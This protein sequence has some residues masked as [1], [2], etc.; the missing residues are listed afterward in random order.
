ML[1]IIIG[2]SIL[3]LCWINI[4]FRAVKTVSQSCP[5]SEAEFEDLRRLFGITGLGSD[6]FLVIYHL[7]GV[8]NNTAFEASHRGEKPILIR[9]RMMDSKSRWNSGELSHISQS[10]LK[11]DTLEWPIN[12]DSIANRIRTSIGPG[13][14]LEAYA[15]PITRKTI[16]VLDPDL[17]Y[18]E[19]G[20][21]SCRRLR[22]FRSSSNWSWIVGTLHDIDSS[23]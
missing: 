1:L 18:L 21:E 2:L 7:H 23:P 10:G 3:V 6:S 15:R 8:G 13:Y 5:E 4:N 11:I 14:V 12:L 17:W 16:H 22:W 19:M 20:K 9:K